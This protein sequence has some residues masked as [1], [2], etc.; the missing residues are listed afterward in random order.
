MVRLHSAASKAPANGSISIKTTNFGTAALRS[1]ADR[2]GS[3]AAYCC[4]SSRVPRRR[5]GNSHAGENRRFCARRGVDAAA[6]TRNPSSAR[7]VTRRNNGRQ[8]QHAPPARDRHPLCPS[9]SE[10]SGRLVRAL[11]SGRPAGQ[12]SAGC[13]AAPRHRGGTEPHPGRGRAT[14]ANGSRAPA[15]GR[16]ERLLRQHDGADAPRAQIARA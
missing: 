10:R 15:R 2:F 3:N 8:S 14:A 12:P 4:A 13:Q 11:V 5:R 9:K 1:I 7:D 16:R 6:W